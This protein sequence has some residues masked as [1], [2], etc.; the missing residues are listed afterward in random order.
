MHRTQGPDDAAGLYKGTPPATVINSKAMNALQ[1]EIART[2][3]GAGLTLA[4]SGTADQVAGWH[5]L[6]EAI[7]VHAGRAGTIA[8]NTPRGELVSFDGPWLE[9]ANSSSYTTSV[10]MAFMRLTGDTGGPFVDGA[11][12][13]PTVGPDFTGRRVTISN[14]SGARKIIHGAYVNNGAAAM[15]QFVSG[16]WVSLAGAAALNTDGLPEGATNK[17]FS[18]KDTDDL[19]EGSTN[20][21]MSGVSVTDTD[22]VPEGSTNKY[23][24]GKDTDDLPE[25]GTNL[26]FSGKDADDLAESS[27]RKFI[28]KLTGNFSAHLYDNAAVLQSSSTIYWQKLDGWITMYLPQFTASITAVMPLRITFTSDAAFPSDARSAFDQGFILFVS[29]DGGVTYIPV[30]AVYD[31]ASDKILIDTFTTGT[32][33]TTT[34][35]TITLRP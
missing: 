13:L 7:R 18:G 17:Y 28:N 12:S 3:E 5:Q 4:V 14:A 31:Q 25:G 9:S 2:I 8:I 34:P 19:P 6:E 26:Y 32:S 21:Y 11:I 33:Y 1:E 27:T 10:A 35:T 15:F 16:G 23:F 24:S 29:N 22:D 20:K 30:R